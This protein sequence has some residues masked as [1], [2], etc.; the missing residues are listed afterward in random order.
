[1]ASPIF[2]VLTAF[3]H[4][5]FMAESLESA[6]APLPIAAQGLAFVLSK[7]SPLGPSRQLMA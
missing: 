3:I 7:S 2:A 1:V 6:M 4:F 5:S